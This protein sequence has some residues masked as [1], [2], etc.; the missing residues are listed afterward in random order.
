MNIDMKMYVSAEWITYIL[1][2]PNVHVEDWCSEGIFGFE[3]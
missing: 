1:M 3:K 2:E